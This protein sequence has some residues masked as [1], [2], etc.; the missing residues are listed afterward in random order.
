MSAI[1]EAGHAVVALQSGK[2][3]SYAEVTREVLVDSKSFDGGCV[4]VSRPDA[5]VYLRSR[6]QIVVMIHHLLGGLAAED[7]F[8]GERNDGGES[9]LREATFWAARMWLSTGQQDILTSF[10]SSDI[11]PVLAALKTRPDIQKKVEEL[12]QQCMSDVKAVIERRRADVRKLADALIERG[13]LSGNEINALLAPK[14][15]QR[16]RLL[17]S[18]QQRDDDHVFGEA[19]Y[20]CA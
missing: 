8:F 12:L 7:I 6:S 14:P 1:H 11:D 13:R 16:L 18:M 5:E 9:D 10:V 4:S 15:R 17:K 19:Y 3:I 2:K 20:A